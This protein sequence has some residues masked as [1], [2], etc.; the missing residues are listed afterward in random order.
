[1]SQKEYYLELNPL[2]QFPKG[3]IYSKVLAKSN[4]FQYTLMCL[5][6]GTDIETHTSTKDACVLVLKGKGSF[7]LR[8]KRIVLKSGVAIFMPA[9]APHSLKASENLAILLCLNG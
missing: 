6:K 4:K 3:G 7:L 1:L 5:T 2:M 9:D 8:K